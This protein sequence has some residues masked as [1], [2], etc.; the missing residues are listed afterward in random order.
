MTPEQYGITIGL[1]IGYTLLFDAMDLRSQIGS[2]GFLRSL[3]YWSYMAFRVLLA[4]L[5]SLLI[6]Q[7]NPGIAL[8]INTLIAVAASVAVLQ[9][10]SLNLS[11]VDVAKLSDLV[12]TYKARM[13]KEEGLRRAKQNESHILRVQRDMIND[14]KS[15]ELENTLR[16]ML[17]QAQWAGD[18]VNSHIESLKKTAGGN[19][20]YLKT[21]MASQIADMNL[22]FARFLV[23][24]Q[25]GFRS[26]PPA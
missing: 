3:T 26:T 23:K 13:V 15:E 11:G 25:R 1:A 22:E 24:Q 10:L 18:K 19:E 17:L 21:M 4:V 14:L 12:D 5:A 8:P 16:Q 9:N 2:F 7:I 20:T 6:F